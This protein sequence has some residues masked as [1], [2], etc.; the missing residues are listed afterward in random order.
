MTPNRDEDVP[1]MRGHIVGYSEERAREQI[2]RV[3]VE[4]VL[5]VLKELLE[6]MRSGV[7]I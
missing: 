3:T 4:E 6:K 2:E 7:S 5:V 1:E